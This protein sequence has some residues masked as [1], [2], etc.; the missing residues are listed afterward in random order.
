MTQHDRR[1]ILWW[2]ALGTGAVLFLA[3]LYFTDFGF[4]ISS[5]RRSVIAVLCALAASGAWHLVRTWAWSHS[6]AKPR[7]VSFRRLARVRLAAEA[8]SYLTL[9]GIAGEPL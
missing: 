9:R 1:A 3:T 7:P 5:G 6:F 8:F 2:G 4:L